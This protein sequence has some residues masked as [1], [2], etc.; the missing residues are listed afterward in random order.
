MKSGA[1]T[2]L[3]LAI[4]DLQ[5]VRMRHAPADF[6]CG[7][8]PEATK[9]TVDYARTQNGTATGIVRGMDF[10]PAS[11]NPEAAP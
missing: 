3:T 6:V 8:Q 11:V 10:S 2:L 7:P 4:P 1:G 5:H 9:V